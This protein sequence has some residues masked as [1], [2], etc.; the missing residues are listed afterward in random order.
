MIEGLSSLALLYFLFFWSLWRI[1]KR[2][3]A[4]GARAESDARLEAFLDELKTDAAYA[5]VC[6]FPYTGA[7]LFGMLERHELVTPVEADKLIDDARSRLPD[8]EP[9]PVA[10]GYDHHVFALN[11]ERDEIP[12]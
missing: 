12:F 4:D 6:E 8:D 10:N 5:A 2:A 1:A 3:H 11:D 9:E 7:D